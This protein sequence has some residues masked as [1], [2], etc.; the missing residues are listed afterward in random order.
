MKLKLLVPLL[1]AISIYVSTPL[2]AEATDSVRFF[3]LGSYTCPHCNALKKFLIDNFGSSCVYFCPVLRNATCWKIFDEI[4]ALCGFP[5]FVPLTLVLVERTNISRVLL[6]EGMQ[7]VGSIPCDK[8]MDVLKRYCINGT[9][10]AIVLGEV[11]DT[12]FWQKIA[13][14]EAVSGNGGGGASSIEQLRFA[15]FLEALI[16]TVVLA[17]I[18]SVNPCTIF[19]YTLLIAAAI[20]SGRSSYRAGLPFVAAVAGGYTL[21]GIGLTQILSLAPIARIVFIALALCLAFINLVKPI[22]AGKGML[23]DYISRASESP[24]LSFALGALATF[25]LLPCSAG[26]YLVFLAY[27]SRLGVYVKTLLMA[28]Y[29]SVFVS[30]LIAIT[31]AGK[32]LERVE[33]IRTMLIEKR[34]AIDIVTA[35][36]LLLVVI[37]TFW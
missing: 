37:L 1:V 34:R 23:F 28:I 9:P 29:I 32:T 2:I 24:L 5:K 22:S 11:R 21:I 7:L 16:K 13:R 10:I 36:L 26:P 27:I 35:I 33:K 4:T 31:I 12:S 6:Y 8:V 18:D 14:G 17:A 25:T 15:S 20:L 30:P 19:I 3:I